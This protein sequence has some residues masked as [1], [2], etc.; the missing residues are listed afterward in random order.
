M[1]VRDHLGNEYDTIKEMCSNWGISPQLFLSRRTRGWGIEKALTTPKKVERVN[2]PVDHLGNKYNSISEMCRAYGIKYNAFSNRIRSGYDL[3]SALTKEVG[4]KRNSVGK[5]VVYRGKEYPSLQSLCNK[6]K[7]SCNTV[8]KRLE[9]GW[10]MKDAITIPVSQKPR[11]GSKG[12]EVKDHLGNEYVTL[13][14]MLN[15]YGMSVYLY[16]SRVNKGWSLE[17]CLTTP[18]Y[19]RDIKPQKRSKPSRFTVKD[20]EGAQFSSKSQ[21]C[22]EWGISYRT[23]CG[24]VRKG[25][26]VKEA[27]TTPV[28]SFDNVDT[29]HLGVKYASTSEMCRH[30]GI[31]V[32]LFSSRVKHGWSVEDALTKP[33]RKKS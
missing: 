16:R 29:D 7:V 26:S 33:V 11:Y 1:R 30:Y 18:K 14:D 13:K 3:E 22:R 32:D 25:W 24:R 2:Q 12:R 5:T 10:T 17:Q 20:H 31:R 23:F 6:H 27:L 28:R 19:T 4:K 9:L 21:M 8:R 15:T